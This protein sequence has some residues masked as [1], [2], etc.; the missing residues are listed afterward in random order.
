MLG[1][2]LVGWRVKTETR[3]AIRSKRQ[4]DDYGSGDY[5][6]YYDDTYDD[7]YEDEDDLEPVSKAV[8]TPVTTTTTTAVPT[9]PHRHHH[10]EAVNPE[11]VD[12]SV[13]VSY[14]T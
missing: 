2:P 10:G 3:P 4:V 1:L 6:E 7:E 9:H 8:T 5:E 14:N 13:P 11:E 12:S